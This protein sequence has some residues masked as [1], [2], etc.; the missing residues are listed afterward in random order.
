MKRRGE[1]SDKLTQNKTEPMEHLKN[2]LITFKPFADYCI[3][4]NLFPGDNF[5]ILELKSQPRPVVPLSIIYGDGNEGGEWTQI[6][7]A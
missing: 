3:D 6:R 4:V 1:C 7:I 5:C 2:H